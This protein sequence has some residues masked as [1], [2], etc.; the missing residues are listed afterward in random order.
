M[1]TVVI[2]VE[3]GRVTEMYK[4]PEL[5]LD[6]IEVIDLDTDDP[7]RKQEAVDY[8]NEVMQELEEVV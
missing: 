2:V 5:E 3:N 7:E 1:K 8:L 4:S 6:D